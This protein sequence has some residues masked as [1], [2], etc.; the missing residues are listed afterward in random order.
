MEHC[1]IDY[2]EQDGCYVLQDMNTSQG[3]YVNEVRVQNAAVRLAAGDLIRFGYSGQTYELV[4]END[5][6]VVIL[7]FS[8][9]CRKHFFPL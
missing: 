1:K 9:Y 5:S 4:L 7:L 2:S 6:Q 3:T 8:F